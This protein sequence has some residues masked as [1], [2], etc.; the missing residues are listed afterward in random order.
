VESLAK[1]LFYFAACYFVYALAA[2]PV[3]AAQR[4]EVIAL[5][6]KA[7]LSLL[8]IP[9]RPLIWLLV[10]P[11]RSVSAAFVCSAGTLG[12]AWVLL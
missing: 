11:Y 12:L 6:E 5:G 9:L 3:G 8:F 7:N 4:R 1:F 10:L 2:Y